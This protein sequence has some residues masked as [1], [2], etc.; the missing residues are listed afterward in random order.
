MSARVFQH[1][2]GPLGHEFGASAG[3]PYGIDGAD[4][5]KDTYRSKLFGGRVS[6]EHA[7][8]RLAR[9]EQRSVN[10]KAT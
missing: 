8:E 7:T 1:G 3:R 5:K 4:L 6:T 2:Y 10:A 9:G